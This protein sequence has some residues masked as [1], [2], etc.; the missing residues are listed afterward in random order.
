MKTITSY[1]V[2]LQY[3]RLVKVLRKFT[4]KNKINIAFLFPQNVIMCFQGYITFHNILN[5]CIYKQIIV[6]EN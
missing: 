2:G 3:K 1:R 6:N 4:I 5:F